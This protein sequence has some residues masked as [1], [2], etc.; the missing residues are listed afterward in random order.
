M[1]A[2]D[3][4]FIRRSLVAFQE[5]LDLPDEERP[6]WLEARRSTDPVLATEIERLLRA[7]AVGAE[8]LPTGGL[9]PPSSPP[10]NQIGHYRIVERIGGG[11]MGEVFVG[12]RSDGLFDHLVAIKRMSP[13]LLPDAARA[14]FEKERRALARLSHR[15]IAQL[16]D[17]GVDDTGAPYLIME[18]V[19]GPPIDQH[20]S[21]RDLSIRD[22]AGHIASVCD[23]V[24]HAHQQLIVHADLK[25]ANILV[26]ESGDPKI[27]D[28]GVARI[29]Q[30]AE[31]HD[32]AA[33]YP[34]TP[35]YASPQRR[36]GASP[37]PS[38]DV[39]SIGVILREL[40]T[41]HPAAEAKDPTTSASDVL[42]QVE[43]PEG[44]SREWADQ[45]ARQ[46]AGD[47][48]AIIMRACAPETADRYPSA[49]E[50]SDDLSAWLDHRPLKAKRGD[51]SYVFAKFLRR[52][53]L[54]VIAATLAAL[55][56]VVSLTT[57]TV[58][59]ARADR[60]RELAEARF[61]E[62]RS[63]AKYLLYDVY[64]R[65]EHTPH[66]LAMR[67]DVAGVAQTYLNQLA[68][69]PSAPP[70]VKRE[71]VE[72]LIRIS[73]LQAGRRH[74]NLGQAPAAQANLA[75]A[76]ELLAELEKTHPSPVENASQQ[77][78]ID[79]LRGSL[80]MNVDQNLEEA[81]RFLSA[82]RSRLAKPPATADGFADLSVLALVETADLANWKS[83]YVDSVDLA[84][85]AIALI[86]TLPAEKR[87]TPEMED[88]IIRVRTS[89]ADGLFYQDKLD[90]AEA[91][92]RKTIRHAVSYLD[93]H[94]D[95][96]QARRHVIVARWNLGTTRLS[97]ND[98]REA[99]AEL[100]A[101]A[102]LLPAL[103]EFEP[104][105]DNALRTETVLLSARAQALVMSGR[106]EEGLASVQEQLGKRRAR[107]LANPGIS[108]YARSYAIL[109][110]MK[111]DLLAD[112][113]HV[114]EA[115]SIYTEANSIFQNLQD[116]G[117]VSS[118]D[119]ATGGWTTLRESM[120]KHCKA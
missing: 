72:S 32:V 78:R 74:S 99:L 61:T 11:G 96:V 1:S 54:R 14:L 88:S 46:C 107:Y 10:P 68:Q 112:N 106:L 35:A 26:N 24:Q 71:V 118:F 97:R 34:Q 84:R 45:R 52:R 31:R 114:A 73:E 66:T 81:D 5:A 109:L 38:D 13:S 16:Y 87:D 41:R 6:A 115:C 55:G 20:V 120:A 80:S 59:Y 77:I 101:A 79:L 51:R 9:R 53:R 67:R 40:I 48:D 57:V 22:I 39:Y 113:K 58:L 28:F 104:T 2:L 18:L 86:D 90:D 30:E 33:I 69:T 75:R 65:L 100:N 111:A 21:A 4:D 108:E 3:V 116:L 15:H 102:L 43:L 70:A 8:A 42:L 76:E 23:A 25:P 105:D 7:D 50:M 83:Q 82:A 60:A 62:V 56:I 47:L 91:E 19:R 92:Y 64:D 95:D 12:A 117:R 27:V 93:A 110:A 29:L 36:S 85:Q 119:L 44:R 49:A 37:S 63:L 89:L 98:P 94:P 103:I 17:G